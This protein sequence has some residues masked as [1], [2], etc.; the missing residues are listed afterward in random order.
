MCTKR[1]ISADRDS[2]VNEIRVSRREETDTIL[3]GRVGAV[4]L[5]D[6]NVFAGDKAVP[7]ELESGLAIVGA[8]SIGEYPAI[9]PR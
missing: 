8:G 6:R 2:T 1:L 5:D 3:K 4:M 7:A 9:L